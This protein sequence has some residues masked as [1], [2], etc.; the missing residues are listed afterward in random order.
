MDGEVKLIPQLRIGKFLNQAFSRK[1]PKVF[2]NS[3]SIDRPQSTLYTELNYKRFCWLKVS[4]GT[5]YSRTD[6]VKFVEDSL[7]KNVK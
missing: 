1:F 6:Q 3:F 2:K 5:R 7:L 4:N